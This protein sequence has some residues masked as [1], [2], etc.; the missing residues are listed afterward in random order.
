M[1]AELEAALL[2]AEA[3]V[4]ESLKQHAD[5]QTQLHA[6]QAANN[7]L[8]SAVEALEQQSLDN[9]ARAEKAESALKVRLDRLDAAAL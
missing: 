6:S 1:Q 3:Q 9:L 5:L 7:E 4:K 2:A 8:R